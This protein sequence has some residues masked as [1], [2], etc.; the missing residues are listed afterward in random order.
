MLLLRFQ[1]GYISYELPEPDNAN[2]IKYHSGW[3][4]EIH[5]QKRKFDGLTIEISKS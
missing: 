5:E 1:S 4:Y 2:V 3:L